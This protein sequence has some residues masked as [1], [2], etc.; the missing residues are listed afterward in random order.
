MPIFNMARKQL[1]INHVYQGIRNNP[2]LFSFISE[3]R[4]KILND[5]SK[6]KDGR[7]KTMMFCLCQN[8]YKDERRKSVTP[9]VIRF[10]VQIIITVRMKT[11]FT[12]NVFVFKQQILSSPQNGRNSHKYYCFRDGIINAS[13][14]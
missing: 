3:N 7:K 8:R 11:H 14:L 1:I 2:I 4:L 13:Q 9:A 5:E 12:S 10:E 6:Y